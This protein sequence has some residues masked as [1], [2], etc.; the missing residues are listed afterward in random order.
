MFQVPLGGLGGVEDHG[1]VVGFSFSIG[2]SSVSVKPKAALV[3]K[4][5]LVIRGFLMKLKYAR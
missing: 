1:D 4:R 5:R 3:L 2:S